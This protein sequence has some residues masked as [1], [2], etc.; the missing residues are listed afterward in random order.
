MIKKRHNG[1]VLT[2]AKTPT[3]FHLTVQNHSLVEYNSIAYQN[4]KLRHLALK[5]VYE[6][7]FMI[8][9]E[10]IDATGSNVFNLVNVTMG[11]RRM[12]QPKF[13]TNATQFS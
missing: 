6:K 7:S 4:I 5:K 8:S 13:P 10:K 11:S 12:E 2:A 3:K 9:Q 1:R